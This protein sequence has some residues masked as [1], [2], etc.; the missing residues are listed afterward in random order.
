MCNGNV[1]AAD[2]SLKANSSIKPLKAIS[3]SELASHNTP[4]SAWCAVHNQDSDGTYT[5]G[6]VVL[7][8]TNFAAKHPGGD[9]ILLAAGKDASVL[10]ETYHPRGVPHSLVKKLQIG[11][12]EKGSFADSFYSWNSDF[13]KVLKKRVVER[14]EERG[15]NRRGSVEIWIKALFLLTGF[16]FSLLQ[17][18]TNSNFFVAMAWSITMG[19]FA[20]MIGTN[21]Q[22][23]GNHGAFAQSK[24]MNKCAGWTLDMIGASAFTW[25]FQHMLGHHPYTNVLDGV[26]EMKKEEGVDCKIEEKDQ[27]SDPDVFSSFPLMRMHPFHTPAWFHRYQH[28]YAPF[29]FALM[30]LAKVFQQDYEV[31][32]SKRLYHIDA[33]ARYGSIW[34]V[35]R[36]W[37]MKF[38]TMIYMMGLP[39]YFHGAAKGM[40]LFVIGHLACGELL[41]TMFIVNHVIEGVSYAKKDLQGVKEDGNDDT[42]KVVG[43]PATI[44]GDTPMEKTRQQAMESSA[45]NSSDENALPSVPFNDW[46]A[47]QC[48]TSVNWAPGSWF[49]NHFSGGLSHQIEHHLFPS[50]CHTNYAY[51]QDVVEKTCAEYGVPYQCEP[52]LLVAYGK[53]LSHL[54]Y[55]GRGKNE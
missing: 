46:A 32:V 13:Y 50:I 7:D 6:H 24:F 16:W 53:M 54:K 37:S 15:L 34:N 36:F 22:H 28:I 44:N 29:L 26:E 48:Q 4:S 12:M 25:E 41:A 20:A 52:S 18:Y 19:S 11:V 27:E 10:F 14:I 47:V 17:M 31:A 30:T 9:L 3:K 39:I 38:I 33:Q 55:M 2:A 8:I 21:I 49:W 45:N 40:A 42:S 23:D 35:F 5:S 1:P 51:I 43:K